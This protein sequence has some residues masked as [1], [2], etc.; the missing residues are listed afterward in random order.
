MNLYGQ[1][2]QIDIAK[3]LN[4]M[5]EL[6]L[7]RFTE[8]K[9]LT[10]A[11][12]LGVESYTHNKD[13]KNTIT[14]V[15]YRPANYTFV[16]AVEGGNVDE[17]SEIKQYSYHD[18]CWRDGTERVIKHVRD[19]IC[20][21][22]ENTGLAESQFSVHTSFDLFGAKIIE[23]VIVEDCDYPTQAEDRTKL[24]FLNKKEKTS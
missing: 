6:A 24:I 11:L 22:I 10:V 5:V 13:F 19:V 21:M 7:P 1:L 3:A 18:S 4:E 20:K 16:G 8:N 15:Y 9:V 14:L 17:N 12:K 23:N 2:T